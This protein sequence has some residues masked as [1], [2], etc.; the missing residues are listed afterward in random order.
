MRLSY[1]SA[2]QESSY[3]TREIWWVRWNW[4]PFRPWASQLS[5]TGESWAPRAGRNHQATGGSRLIRNSNT[6]WFSFRLTKFQI[7]QAD[8]HWGD[9]RQVCNE[10]KIQQE[11]RLSKFGPTGI[12]LYWLGQWDVTHSC[13]WTWGVITIRRA[14][15]QGQKEV[16]PSDPAEI[17]VLRIV[18][19]FFIFFKFSLVQHSKNIFHR[20]PSSET[21][22]FLFAIHLFYFSQQDT[23]SQDKK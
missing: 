22:F 11:F 19:W 5:I 10:L 20:N 7:K 4:C 17:S 12:H 21:D 13:W 14:S 16:G 15:Q 9:K 18:T 6:K 2:A 1:E 23:E 3:K 8:W